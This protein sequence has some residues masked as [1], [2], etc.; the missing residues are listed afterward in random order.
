MTALYSYLRNNTLLPNLLLR[1]LFL[2]HVRILGICRIQFSLFLV[3]SVSYF[4]V[5]LQKDWTFP[6]LWPSKKKIPLPISPTTHFLYPQFQTPPQFPFFSLRTRRL[7]PS[8][9]HRT[10]T[11]NWIQASNL[12]KLDLALNSI[13]NIEVHTSEATWNCHG[14]PLDWTFEPTEPRSDTKAV[15]NHKAFTISNQVWAG[16][17]FNWNSSIDQDPDLIRSSSNLKLRSR[18]LS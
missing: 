8:T 16:E 10:N 6:L 13:L 5:L 2:T 12:I 18:I 15:F 11:E 9:C 4:V 7:R 17:S 3:W 1:M 14:S